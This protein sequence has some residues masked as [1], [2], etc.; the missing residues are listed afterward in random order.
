MTDL[1]ST[2]CCGMRELHGLNFRNWN[3]VTRTSDLSPADQ[4]VR[5]VSRDCFD[6]DTNPYCMVLFTD[7]V[8]KYH[9]QGTLL[10]NYIY[11]NELGDIIETP[12][13]TNPNTNNS[14]RAWIW[15]INKT[16]LRSW[17]RKNGG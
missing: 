12:V 1:R 3:P 10:A 14:I 4:L 8:S 9:Q 15:T 11:D 7:I 2:A 5:V 16:K 6:R 13:K 17:H